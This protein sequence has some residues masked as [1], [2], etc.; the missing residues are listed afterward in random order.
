MEN[1]AP[2]S[3]PPSP[4]PV[5]AP[6]SSKKQAIILIVLGLVLIAATA[7][8]L[9]QKYFA[10]QEPTEALTVSE[11]S[12]WKTYRNEEYG[13]EFKYNPSNFVGK[14]FDQPETPG[15]LFS[16]VLS[17]VT[18]EYG[19]P[20]FVS[21]SIWGNTQDVSLLDWA[22]KNSSFSNYDSTNSAWNEFKN[23]TV[24]DRKAISF[25]W[26]GGVDGKTVIIDNGKTIILL[27]AG[28]GVGTPTHQVWQDFESILSTFKFISTSTSEIDISNWI[29]AGGDALGFSLL[30]PPTTKISNTYNKLTE[31]HAD[32]T[33]EN[34]TQDQSDY[35]YLI[36]SNNRNFGIDDSWTETSLNIG[37]IETTVL[38]QKT[39]KL[40]RILFT[41]KE[42]KWHAIG[43]KSSGWELLLKVLE[44]LK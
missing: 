42:R 23:E 2:L 43:Y 8:F 9:Y 33:I 27:S 35:F 1:Q 18:K 11:F 14:T 25:L 21:V 19:A 36:Q 37:G 7:P 34:S 12:D 31:P 13:F 22:K 24:G 5:Q 17:F 20:G 44:T 16:I 29:P 28:A 32:F 6:K 39:E 41:Y 40:N 3:V 4:A 26:T 15:N 10:P 30:V 38:M